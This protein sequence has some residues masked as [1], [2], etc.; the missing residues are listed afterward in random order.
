MAIGHMVMPYVRVTQNS[1]EAAER[2]SK[3][4]EQIYD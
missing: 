2:H 1:E 3:E 4:N